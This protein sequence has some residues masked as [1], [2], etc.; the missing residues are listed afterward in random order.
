IAVDMALKHIPNN[1]PLQS[2]EHEPLEL[3]KSSLEHILET[4]PPQPT[5]RDPEHHGGFTRGPTGTSLL[6][7]RLAAL[8]PDVQVAGRSLMHWAERY[9]EGDRGE[10]ALANRVGI[11]CEKLAYEALKACVSKDEND[12]RAFLSN[13]PTV[14]GPCPDSERDPFVSE[15]WQGRAGTLYCM[16]LMRHHLPE[17][18]ALLEGPIA[19]VSDKIMADSIDEGEG[20]WLCHHHELLGAAHGDMGIITQVVL[21]TPSLA[22]R[23]AP[24]LRALLSL[25]V[26]GNWPIGKGLDETRHPRLM[27]WCHGAPGFVVSLHAIRPHFPELRDQ[28]DVAIAEGEEAIWKLGLLR[29]EPSLCHGLFGNALNLPRGP[30]REHFLSLA[31][32]EAIGKARSADPKVF[33]PADYGRDMALLF[34]YHSSAAWAWAVCEWENPPLIAYTD[35]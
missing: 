6:F 24:K 18:A 16:R 5:Y 12:V 17:S 13:M 35:V 34:K 25:Q 29:K 32:V 8:Y 19:Q 2:L 14:A 4:T 30:R 23:L 1:L 20:G 21:T 26:D 33:Q 11:G 27:Q 22:P 7:F 15:M 10:L 28:I 9:L 31:T 3:M